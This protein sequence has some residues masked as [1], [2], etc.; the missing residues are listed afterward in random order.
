MTPSAMED[1]FAFLTQLMT[2][3]A[4]MFESIGNNMFRAFATILIVWFGVKSALASA[5]GGHGSGFHFDH[6]ASLL[7]TVAVGFGMIPFY[8]H[9]IPGFAVSFYQLFLD[10]GLDLANQL[11]HSLGQA[12]CD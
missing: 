2:E 8:S 3:H 1:L 12:L 9:P 6:F 5:G 10:Q 4:G 11:N 7:M